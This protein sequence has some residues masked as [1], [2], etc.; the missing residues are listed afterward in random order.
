MQNQ[1]LHSISETPCASQEL[2]NAESLNGENPLERVEPLLCYFTAS[3]MRKIH[4]ALSI[5]NY[6]LQSVRPR[7]AIWLY[8]GPLSLNASDL[9]G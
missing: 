6:D 7:P 4:L 3:W 5:W 8:K 2:L 1:P 9:E